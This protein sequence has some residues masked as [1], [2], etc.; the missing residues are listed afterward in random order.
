MD[1]TQDKQIPKIDKDTFICM[2]RAVG[3]SMYIQLCH[4]FE[5]FME[6]LDKEDDNDEGTT[7][8]NA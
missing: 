3:Y 1:T 4:A 6:I 8:S 2:P 5:K 7:S